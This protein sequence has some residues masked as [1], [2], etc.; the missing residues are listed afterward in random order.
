MSVTAAIF[1]RNYVF[2]FPRYS[3]FPYQTIFVRVPFG[4]EY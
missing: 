3:L 4:L 1:Y 2:W